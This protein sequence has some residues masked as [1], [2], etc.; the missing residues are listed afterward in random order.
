MGYRAPCKF[1]Q[2]GRC[3]RGSACPFAHEGQGQRQ[4]ERPL[5]RFFAQGNCQFG[6]R[7]HNRHDQAAGP[8]GG[9][10]APGEQ[11]QF[12]GSRI[13]EDP[14]I[15]QVWSMEVHIPSTLLYMDI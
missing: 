9:S 1:Y 10:P 7:C 11:Q 12:M 2:E 3:N 5:C 15:M 4:T 14:Q 8:S 13:L 6:D